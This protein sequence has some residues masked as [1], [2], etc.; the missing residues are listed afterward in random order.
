MRTLM[1]L[2]FASAASVGHG[3]VS[4]RSMTSSD[5]FS[6]PLLFH[7]A[8]DE[9]ARP[10]ASPVPIP[11]DRVPSIGLFDPAQGVGRLPLNLSVFIPFGGGSGGHLATGSQPLQLNLGNVLELIGLGNGSRP[12]TGGNIS[13]PVV[14]GAG[15]HL[16]VGNRPVGIS[17]GNIGL[18]GSGANSSRPV[19]GAGG[20][21]PVTGDAAGQ[22]GSRPLTWFTGSQGGNR[23]VTGS[24]GSQSGNRPFGSG[25]G[26]LSSGN[27]PG[28]GSSFT[29]PRPVLS[30]GFGLLGS[31]GGRPTVR[32]VLGGTNNRPVQVGIGTQTGNRPRPVVGSGIGLLGSRPQVGE[33]SNRPVLGGVGAQVGFGNRPTG[34]LQGG[35]VTGGQNAGL[36]VASGGGVS[37]TGTATAQASGSASASVSGGGNRPRPVVVGVSSTLGGSPSRP[38]IGS[39]G[40]TQ[41][42]NPSRPVAGGQP[43]Q[44]GN[45]SRPVVGIGR[46]TQGGNPSRPVLGG[47]GLAQGVGLGGVSAGLGGTLFGGNR[48]TLGIV[49]GGTV[50][51]S[52]IFGTNGLG[53]VGSGFGIPGNHVLG[54]GFP[55]GFGLGSGIGGSSFGGYRPG[56]LLNYLAGVDRPFAGAF[57]GGFGSGYHQHRP[58]QPYHGYYP[59]RPYRPYDPYHSAF[60]P[61]RPYL[62][63]YGRDDLRN[64][65]NL[66]VQARKAN[67]TI[68]SIDDQDDAEDGSKDL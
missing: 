65:G 10:A 43:T 16:S 53:Y 44:G 64:L 56:G 40:V 12:L 36:S 23:P 46:P 45:P 58:Y 5:K 26:L 42:G 59:Y 9:A 25:I 2:L 21:R 35:G 20:N 24:A 27:R 13:T 60:N 4:E 67:S 28:L 55:G 7:N 18:S 68:A 47:G 14:G 49:P 54:V 50:P 29:I 15:N 22:A 19:V 6:E 41:G 3:R 34:G 39:G 31:G 61:Y 48:P 1:L 66:L 57:G 32:P 17:L 51:I 30:T 33:G 62:Y 8:T 52:S 37:T 11:K 63:G 38:V